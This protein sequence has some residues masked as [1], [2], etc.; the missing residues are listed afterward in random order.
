VVPGSVPVSSAGGLTSTPSRT[1]ATVAVGA[2]STSPSLLVQ[3]AS[4]R[5]CSS[6][7]RRLAMFTA[8]DVLFTPPSSHGASVRRPAGTPRV[9]VTALTPCSRPCSV[10]AGTGLAS[11]K[12]TGVP[13]GTP[14]LQVSRSTPS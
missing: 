11:A 3:T 12:P 13:P 14:L 5:P 7:A 6:A 10:A 1:Q 2:S 4:W 9:S 8:Y